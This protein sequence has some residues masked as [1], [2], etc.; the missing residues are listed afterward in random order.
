MIKVKQYRPNFFTGFDNE[1]H[2]VNTVAELLELEF[3][4]NFTNQ[5]DEEK[6]FQ[7]SITR[8]RD[9]QWTLIAEYNE[10]KKYLV[11][12]FLTADNDN[13]LTNH[14]VK[15]VLTPAEVD[16]PTAEAP[17]EAEGTPFE[18]DVEGVPVFTRFDKVQPI[19][20]EK[21]MEQGDH[22]AYPNNE[23]HLLIPLKDG[24][25]GNLLQL[26][27]KF[28]E[29]LAKRGQP[30]I[31]GMVMGLQLFNAD[32]VQLQCFFDNTTDRPP[33]QLHQMVHANSPF[34]YRSPE[35]KAELQKEWFSR[36]MSFYNIDRHAAWRAN[37]HS[38]LPLEF[39]IGVL[40]YDQTTA[41]YK[42]ELHESYISMGWSIVV[43]C[44]I[45]EGA[46]R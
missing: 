32:G 36:Q 10:G 40:Q 5:N 24:V 3:V 16:P 41:H 20:T 37:A 43:K 22:F 9:N 11:V 28:E 8:A 45:V 35:R 19:P 26:T 23:T 30:V 31:A 6:F 34:R 17:S 15:W 44:V 27:A 1:E 13:D 2:E 46:F 4:K 21:T 29:Q 42:L 7:F 33:T 12:A 25:E 14:L 39:R 18:G 38:I